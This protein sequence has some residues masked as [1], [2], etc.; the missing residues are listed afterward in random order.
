MPRIKH[1]WT[2][3][4][5]FADITD[6]RH[7]FLLSA[8][9]AFNQ[10]LCMIPTIILAISVASNFLDE[11][12]TKETVASV[13]R[14]LLPS[15]IQATETTTLIVRELGAVFNYSTIAGWFAGVALIWVASALF[16]SMRTGLNA[17]FH[18]PTPKFFVWYK[19][20]DLV[21]TLIV[22][23]MV[24]VATVTL[25]LF[26]ILQGEWS[27][28]LHG[29]PLIW[30]ETLGAQVVSIIFTTVFFLVLYATVPNKRLPLPIIAM[31]TMFAVLL[32][33]IARAAFTWYVN[34]AS[35]L[36]KFYGGYLALA[37][38]ALWFYYSSMVFLLS[39]ELAQFIYVRR[40]EHRSPTA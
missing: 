14:Q 2:L 4:A 21:L 33:E 5:E 15:G 7:I 22:A 23:L 8:G 37:S 38:L 13:L 40:R 19:I 34:S 11:Q 32:W 39:A 1:W 28:W 24:V 16:G 25:P 6:R 12:A 17:I 31:S 36:S 3:V 29:S 9:I 30:L 18:I 10:L 20:K 27:S 26:S 35:N